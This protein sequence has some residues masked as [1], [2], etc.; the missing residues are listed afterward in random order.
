MDFSIVIPAYNEAAKIGTDVE[1]AA[2]FLADANMRGEV[3]VVDDGSSDGTAAAARR[4]AVPDRVSLEVIRYEPNRGKGYA[5]RQGMLATTGRFVMFADS[6]LCVPFIESLRG[7]ELIRSGQCDVAHA[8]RKLPETHIERAQSLYRRA[9][10]WAFRTFVFLFMGVPR[11]LTDTQCGYKIY[12][13]DV[14]RELYAE[15]KSDGFMFDVEVILRADRHGYTIAEFPVDWT[16]DPDSRLHPLHV[17]FRV[18]R[19]LLAVKRMMGKE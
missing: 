5:V 4:V 19:E 1:A 7:L 9:C 12:R 8:S 13:G 18:L 10:S 2:H 3:I 16:N 11:H 17:A 15:C 14:A 6:G